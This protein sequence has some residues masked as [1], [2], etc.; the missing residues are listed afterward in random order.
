M[1]TRIHGLLLGVAVLGILLDCRS[2]DSLRAVEKMDARLRLL[3]EKNRDENV[4]FT[5]LCTEAISVETK[6]QIE[7]TGVVLQTVTGDRFT[8]V[9]QPLQ[10]R[11]LARL[12]F[13]VRLSAA[14]PVY[15]SVK[16][17]SFR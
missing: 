12:V 7:H 10:I 13:V 11:K 4:H 1:K 3:T 15:P 16:K 6:A 5:G 14:K 2:P 17:E 8:A 9:G